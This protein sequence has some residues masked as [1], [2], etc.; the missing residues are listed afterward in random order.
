MVSVAAAL[1]DKVEVRVG[2]EEEGGKQA[3]AERKKTEDAGTSQLIQDR[4]KRPRIR[5]RLN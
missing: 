2:K 1:N 5:V 4:G 3:T